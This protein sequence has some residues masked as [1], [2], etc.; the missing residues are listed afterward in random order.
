M[1]L[2][3]LQEQPTVQL[4][5]EPNV[6]NESSTPAASNV[7][8][9]AQVQPVQKKVTRLVNTTQNIASSIF[10]KPTKEI[11]KRKS[12]NSLKCPELQ[13]MKN[14]KCNMKLR[15]AIPNSA[16]DEDFS[17]D[18]DKPLMFYTKKT[19]KSKR[20]TKKQDTIVKPRKGIYIF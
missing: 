13:K 12:R 5:H 10:T 1:L 18:D 20:M 9:K 14:Q 17:I 8:T 3:R 4:D 16:V 2:E 7:T 6:S 15:S 19:L 11:I